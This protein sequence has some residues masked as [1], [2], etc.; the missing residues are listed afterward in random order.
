MVSSATDMD[1]QDLLTALRRMRR[2]YAADPE[3]K[4]L[5]AELPKGWP[6]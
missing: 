2:E 1:L 4:K 5:R 6:I 3:Y